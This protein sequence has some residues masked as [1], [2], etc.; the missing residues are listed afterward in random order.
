MVDSWNSWNW[1]L[2]N[3]NTSDDFP[4]AD[5]PSKTNWW[6]DHKWNCFLKAV[7]IYAKLLRSNF[8]LVTLKNK[9]EFLPT[10]IALRYNRIKG[11]YHWWGPQSTWQVSF[12]ANPLNCDI[13]C[14]DGDAPEL[15]PPPAPGR[16]AILLPGRLPQN[17]GRGPQNP[18][19]WSHNPGR[20]P[21]FSPAVLFLQFLVVV[22]L[23]FLPFVHQGT[24][25]HG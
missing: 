6:G 23:I 8:I 7:A 25:R 2:T 24:D 3:R 15:P 13:L 5:S 10:W 20:P 4:T 11:Q 14:P 21:S 18:G 17:E 9:K 16:D 1:P 12:V 19:C 22:N